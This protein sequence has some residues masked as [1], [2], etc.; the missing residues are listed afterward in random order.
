MANALNTTNTKSISGQ[1]GSSGNGLPVGKNGYNFTDKDRSNISNWVQA[2]VPEGPG[3]DVLLGRI[4]NTLASGERSGSTTNFNTIADSYSTSLGI[5]RQK[6]AQTSNPWYQMVGNLHEGL[7]GDSGLFPWIGGGID[8]LGE[9]TIGNLIGAFGGKQAQESF[10]NAIT[11]QD[12]AIIPDIATD[13]VFAPFAP[14]K[15]GI[16]ESPNLYRAVEGVDPV[17]GEPVSDFQKAMSGGAAA[18]DIALSTIPGL[19]ALGKGLRGATKAARKADE[20]ATNAD[21]WGGEGK[22]MWSQLA[23]DAARAEA[24]RGAVLSDGTRNAMHGADEEAILARAKQIENERFGGGTKAEKLEG[25]KQTRASLDEQ[26]SNAQTALTEG[27]AAA[28][29]DWVPIQDQGSIEVVGRMGQQAGRGTGFG[30]EVY[31]VSIPDGS[32]GSRIAYARRVPDGKNGS[33]WEELNTDVYSRLGEEENLAQNALNDL[34]A[35]ILE[36]RNGQNVISIDNNGRFAVN[37]QDVLA[38]PD[39]LQGLDDAYQMLG[40][41]VETN[42]IG[43][44]GRQA[45]EDLGFVPGVSGLGREQQLRMLGSLR[46]DAEKAVTRLAYNGNA[47]PA[48]VSS[49]STVWDEVS[50]MMQGG[51]GTP[52]IAPAAGSNA[53]G[54]SFSTADEKA[55]MD[56]YNTMIAAHN[57]PAQPMTFRD[58]ISSVLGE[59]E[60]I[61]VN[62]PRGGAN[63]ANYAK[64]LAAR[65]AGNEAVAAANGELPAEAA[66]AFGRLPGYGYRTGSFT[67]GYVPVSQSNLPTRY[68]Y[69]NDY[70]VPGITGGSFDVARAARLRELQ[71]TYDKEIARLQP[72]MDAADEIATLYDRAMHPWREAGRE[73]LNMAVPFRPSTG[74]L[75]TSLDDFLQRFRGNYSNEKA[76]SAAGDRAARKAGADVG[77]KGLFKRGGKETTEND[78]QAAARKEAEA[79]LRAAY[80]EPADNAVESALNLFR[81]W[82]GDSRSEGLIRNMMKSGLAGLGSI[83][84]QTMN[85]IAN[86]GIEDPYA[87]LSEIYADNPLGPAAALLMPMFGRTAARRA[88]IPAVRYTNRINAGGIA[89][90]NAAAG[91][92]MGMSQ[93][94]QLMLDA[95]MNPDHSQELYNSWVGGQYEGMPQLT[96]N[97]DSLKLDDVA[98]ILASYRRFNGLDEDLSDIGWMP[99]GF[100]L[101][102]YL[103]AYR[104]E[105]QAQGA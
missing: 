30:Q 66:E 41:N 17:T 99:E 93:E 2:H 71:G 65:R 67:Q 52:K 76:I 15:A 58:V 98:A 3:R 36:S 62:L 53:P 60:P 95:M 103:D 27:R 79:S 57:G 87:A 61:A 55:I 39:T 100:T 5:P 24:Q 84:L 81:R 59:G 4:A 11:G 51:R 42:G 9:A 102:D 90:M 29:L 47:L 40:Q 13:I 83:P 91:Q 104:T 86:T 63:E 33:V 85:A 23:E 21:I 31:Q 80:E 14:V 46:P 44:I 70:V 26:A 68:I 12:L 35:S 34:N 78:T 18:F 48:N 72:Q 75:P 88:G 105:L 77:K 73:W 97:P 69:G 50:R 45:W 43:P 32:G 38:S 96:S 22:T 74:G 92:P 25:S 49:S 8:A 94:D 64:I 54:I 10:N 28:E 20:L 37:Q 56:F 82:R 101:D 6:K 89:G 19:G 1:G 16:R 7:Y